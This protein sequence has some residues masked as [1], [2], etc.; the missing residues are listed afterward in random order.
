MENQAKLWLS[1]PSC[2]QCRRNESQ[3][4]AVYLVPAHPVAGAQLNKA[5]V[6]LPHA[7]NAVHSFKASDLKKMNKEP[8]GR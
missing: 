3:S 5:S 6:C 1:Q 2:F 4:P 8:Q 7:V